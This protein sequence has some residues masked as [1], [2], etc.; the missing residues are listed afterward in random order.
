[1]AQTVLAP[2][3]G[4]IALIN[5]YL[6]ALDIS[7]EVWSD[8]RGAGGKDSVLLTV[9]SLALYTSYWGKQ[10]KPKGHEGKKQG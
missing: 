8:A 3:Q 9:L 10:I 2:H 1:M 7:I 4:C 6:K 5:L